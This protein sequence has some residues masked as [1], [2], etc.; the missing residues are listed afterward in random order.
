MPSHRDLLPHGSAG[1][2]S[3]VPYAGPVDRAELI[4]YVR[5]QRDAVVASVGPDGA[6]QAAYLTIAAT[7]QGELVFD[8]KPD[9][10]KVANVRR[11]PR[12]AIV[13]GGRDGTTLQCEGA[14]DLPDGD[15]LV[16]CAAAYVDAFPEFAASVRAGGVVVIR[17]RVEWARYGDFR[18][19][20]PDVRTVD[21]AAARETNLPR[22]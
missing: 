17:V 12:V 20:P 10:R 13:V 4:A 22:T 15:D 18:G 9:S 2:E 3:A 19:S 16:R 7:D 1:D 5:S 8:A 6:P 21:I 11:D 14:A